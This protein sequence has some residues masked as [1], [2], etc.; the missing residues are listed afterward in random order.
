MHICLP[1]YLPLSHASGLSLAP[2]FYPCYNSIQFP[3]Q[4]WHVHLNHTFWM[5][6]CHLGIE[7]RQ[8]SGGE[9]ADWGKRIVCQSVQ[10]SEYIRCSPW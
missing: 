1:V 10:H 5:G 4:D 6:L 3:G 7:R 9:R 2:A 8:G